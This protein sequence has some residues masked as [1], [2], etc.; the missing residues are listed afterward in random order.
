MATEQVKDLVNCLQEDI[1]KWEGQ[2]L[3]FMRDFP[4]QARDIAKEIAAFA[5]SNSGTIYIG[6][7]EDK[8]IIGISES[9]DSIQDRMAGICQKT[10][11]PAI[12]PLLEFIEVDNKSVAK[13]SVPK[14]PEPVYYVNNI[15]YMRNLT[16]SEPATPDQVKELHRKQLLNEILVVD[17][18]GSTGAAFRL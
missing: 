12:V 13:I 1:Q 11:R 3:E 16:A 6:I 15:P 18:I 5:T 9:S 14:G 4:T 17:R 7:A 2:E 10:I 8:S